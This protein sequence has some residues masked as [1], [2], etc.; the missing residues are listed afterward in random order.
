VLRNVRAN[1]A[2]LVPLVSYPLWIGAVVPLM[3]TGRKLE[4][5][6]SAYILGVP[7]LF[8]VGVSELLEARYGLPIDT[9]GLGLYVGLSAIFLILAVA[10]LCNLRVQERHS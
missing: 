10:Y 6:Y 1:R 3:R 5:L 8:T 2:Q 7:L 4:Y 9:G